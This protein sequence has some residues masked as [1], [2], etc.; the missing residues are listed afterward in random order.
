LNQN[1]RLY[2]TNT[3]VQ[4]YRTETP[5]D[6]TPNKEQEPKRQTVSKTH[7]PGIKEAKKITVATPFDTNKERVKLYARD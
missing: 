6:C 2:D 3:T 4:E 7:T 1:S 5:A